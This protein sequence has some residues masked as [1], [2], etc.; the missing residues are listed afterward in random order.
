MSSIGIV[1]DTHG[2]ISMAEADRLGVYVLPMP[3]IIEGKCYYEGV[4][5]DRAEFLSKLK[6]GVNVST[7]QPAPTEVTAIWD[8]ALKDHDQILHMP[9]TSGLSGSYETACM[10]SADEPYKGRVFVVDHG[11]IATPLHMCILDALNLISKGYTAEK[12]QSI[13]ENSKEDVDI[14]IA[15]NT[16]EYLKRGGRIKATTAAVGSLLNIKPV[17]ALRTGKLEMYKNCRGFNKARQTMLE[18]MQELLA[19]KYKDA[20]AKG[21]LNLMAATSA[22]DQTTAAWLATMEKTFPG[23]PITCDPL[24]LGIC[25]HAGEGV[26]GIGC[27]VKPE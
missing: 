7:S 11:R 22:D 27:S 14:F 26:L 5:L 12:I 6:A 23:M 8:K 9:I 4:D 10:L 24:S 13:L 16:L 21:R 17:L 18:T 15:V 3:F 20:L 2:G 19:T 1:T 25:C